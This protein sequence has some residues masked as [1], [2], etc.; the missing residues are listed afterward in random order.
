MTHSLE[1]CVVQL[2]VESR[3]HVV[4]K[5]FGERWHRKK[6]IKVFVVRDGQLLEIPIPSLEQP[7]SK[8]G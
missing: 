7:Q 2:E 5:S 3:W 6:T 8:H 4:S 1:D